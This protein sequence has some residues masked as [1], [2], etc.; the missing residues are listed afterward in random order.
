MLFALRILYTKSTFKETEKK[1][2]GNKQSRIHKIYYRPIAFFSC[3]NSTIHLSLSRITLSTHNN[4]TYYHKTC[5]SVYNK[6]AHL[7]GMRFFLNF[8]ILLKSYLALLIR[9]LNKQTHQAHGINWIVKKMHKT[10]FSYHL[11]FYVQTKNK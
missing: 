10:K 2:S 5:V 7:K 11:I 1:A 6:F 9:K 4:M 8:K 3:F